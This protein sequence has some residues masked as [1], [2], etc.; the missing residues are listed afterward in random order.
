MNEY[1]KA[2]MGFDD[3]TPFYITLAGITYPDASYHIIRPDSGVSVI[4]YVTDGGGWVFADGEKHYVTE[5]TVYFLPRGKRHEYCSDRENPYTKIF[6]NISGDFCDRLIQAYG[7]SG[8]YFFDGTGLLSVFERILTVIRSDMPDCEMQPMLQGVFVEIISRLAVALTET[9][10]N[11][12]ALKLKNYLDSNLNR[13][14]STEELSKTIFRSKDY[15]QKLF[16]RE[17]N[18]TPYAY[19]LDKKMQ[20]ATFLLTDTNMPIGEIAE[21][22]GYTDIHYFSNIFKKKCGCRPSSYRKE[23]R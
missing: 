20:T 2:F 7:L 3:K 10:Y 18:V 21:K 11:N 12:E 15:C 14:V 13:H 8:K 9:E 22:L 23:R 6:L 4:E 17:F 19:Q 5:N 1:L 16:K